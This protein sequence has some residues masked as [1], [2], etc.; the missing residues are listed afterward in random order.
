MSSGDQNRQTQR[1]LHGRRPASTTSRHARLD[2]ASRGIQRRV[3]FPDRVITTDVFDTILLRKPVSERTRF[4][5]AAKL[6]AEKLSPTHA[7]PWQDIY[8]AKQQANKA[9]YRV[10]NALECE[11]EI[12]H[13]QVTQLQSKLL[14]LPDHLADMFLDCELDVERQS[15]KPNRDWT[16]SLKIHRANGGRVIAIS[17]TPLPHD[18]VMSLIEEIA[19][20]DIIDALYVSSDQQA[21][22]RR[23]DLYSY[24]IAKEN[25]TPSNVLHVGD[26]RHADQK[27]AQHFGFRTELKPRPKSHFLRERAD[28]ARAESMRWVRTVSPRNKEARRPFESQLD[29]GERILGPIF[30]EASVL[31]WAHLSAIPKHERT[32]ALFCARGGLQMHRAFQRV[33]ENCA[34]DLDVLIKDFM[35]SRLVSAKAAMAY[36]PDAILDEVGGI[37]RRTSLR[38]FL[39]GFGETEMPDLDWLDERADPAALRKFFD[40]H[41]AEGLKRNLSAHLQ[42]YRK[43]VAQ[44]AEDASHLVLVDTGFFGTTL[45]SMA[46]AFPEYQWSSILL[47]HVRK[48]AVARRHPH[49]LIGLWSDQFGYNPFDRRTALLRHWQLIEVLF[50]PQLASVQSFREEDGKIIS[51]LET[52]GWQEQLE[53]DDNPLYQ[54]M[55]RYLESLKPGDHARYQ[56]IT[57]PAWRRLRQACLFP[58]ASDLEALSIPERSLDFGLEGHYKVNLATAQAGFLEGV[59]QIRHSPWK[60]GAAATAFPS[61]RLL[62]NLG[63]EATYLA[64]FANG[65]RRRRLG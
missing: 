54:G 17:D 46:A 34:L 45:C 55:M 23:G 2:E 38:D 48:P 19:G 43:Y 24:V 51:N 22:K 10:L 47:A 7:R 8:D 44:Q 64:R 41:H 61:F 14:D 6:A 31:L 21:T 39:K 3:Y 65:I 13:A 1:S 56:E 18:A 60:E 35:T 16:A 58:N 20:P 11:G 36:N 5:R 49:S 63:V 57:E 52:P 28:A 27:M 40:S 26:H 32:V 9:C 4:L 25:L 59:N 12:T 37:Y 62:T 53:A 50:E 29:F 33:L 42:L 15:L 30:F